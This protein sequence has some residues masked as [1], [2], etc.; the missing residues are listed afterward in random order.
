[1]LSNWRFAAFVLCFLTF[2]GFSVSSAVTAMAGLLIAAENIAA[3]QNNEI[4]RNSLN[5]ISPFFRKITKLLANGMLS[6]HLAWQSYR[7]FGSPK[8][9]SSGGASAGSR[10][11]SLDQAP[12]SMF[13][14][15]ALQK[16]RK[17][18]DKANTLF[19]PQP[20]QTT[21]LAGIGL[22]SM[23]KIHR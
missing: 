1:M 22:L 21:V 16:G 12:K 7:S 23:S 8:F 13:L 2:T 10:K 15:R 17:G 5:F 20:G 9:S 18:L 11:F 19:P 6:T 3:P 4:S 14:Q